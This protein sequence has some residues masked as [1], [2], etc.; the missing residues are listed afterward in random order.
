MMPQF[1]ASLTNDSRVVI[2]DGKIFMIQVL[3]VERLGKKESHILGQDQRIE[4][5][6][7]KLFST[8]IK[9]AAK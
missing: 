4:A 9:T 1:E 3:G 2:Y 7:I 6:A 5:G 8:F